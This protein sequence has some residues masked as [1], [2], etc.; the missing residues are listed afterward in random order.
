MLIGMIETKKVI[1]KR[2]KVFFR[3]ILLNVYL[4][5]PFGWLGPELQGIKEKKD[6]N[7]EW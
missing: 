5:Q 4:G 3:G 7:I 2:I 1:M 6:H